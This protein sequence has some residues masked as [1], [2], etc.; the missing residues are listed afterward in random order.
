MVPSHTKWYGKV[1]LLFDLV[2][3]IIYN[4]KMCMKILIKNV[5]YQTPLKGMFGWSQVS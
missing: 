2:F 1:F 3:L 5:K 4:I